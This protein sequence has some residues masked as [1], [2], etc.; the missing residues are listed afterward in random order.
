[1]CRQT[2]RPASSRPG[3]STREGKLIGRPHPRTEPG[4][5]TDQLTKRADS[6]LRISWV[7]RTRSWLPRPM[8]PPARPGGG[9]I[10]CC[11]FKHQGRTA[12]I[13]A[14]RGP[15]LARGNRVR[16]RGSLAR[17]LMVRHLTLDQ[18]ILGSNPSAPANSTTQRSPSGKRREGLWF[19]LGITWPGTRETASVASS[20]WLRRATTRAASAWVALRGRGA[21]ARDLDRDAAPATTDLPEEDPHGSEPR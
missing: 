7:Y 6:R 19:G 5:R 12:S 20:S 8:A 14:C 17:G 21:I 4:R 10:V 2:M 3:R 9:T 16:F 13:G 18:G 1:M 11:Q 15:G